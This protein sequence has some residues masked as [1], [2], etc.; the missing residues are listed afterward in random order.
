MAWTSAGADQR[1][2]FLGA[3]SALKQGDRQAFELLAV[4]LQEY[5]LYPYLRFEVLRRDLDSASAEEVGQFID[6]YGD[7]PLAERLRRI[8]LDRLAALSDWDG[9]VR[10]YRRGDSTER[11]C[12]YLQALTA[13]GRADEALPQVEAVWLS[14]K[15]RPRACD[16][17]IETWMDA[18][19]LT[20]DLVW[21]RIGLAM[22]AGQT[23]LARYLDR[24]L[25]PGE[26]TWL[27]R[28]LAL[29]GDPGRVLELGELPE[30]HPQRGRILAYGVERLARTS[31]ERAAKSLDLLER[32]GELSEDQIRS[33]AAAVGFALAERGDSKGLAYLDRV[34]A[35]NSNL[36]FQERRLRLA[37]TL[38]DWPVVARWVE[39]MP[40]GPQKTE[41]WV[42]WL[43][44]AREAE[45][46]REE[47]LRLFRQ[48]A[49]ERSLWGF[50]AAD[51]SGLP[52]RLDS[53][54]VP[55][56]PKRIASIAQGPAGQRIR[57]LQA[58]ERDLDV[59]REWYHLTR[60]LDAED[61][62]AAAVLACR[63]GLPDQ[64]IFTLARSDYWD[65]LAL[66]FPLLY[67][68]EVTQQ[69][70]ATGLDESLIYAVL[71]QESA[72]NPAAVSHAGAMGLMQLMPA[73]ARG[74][75]G[76]LGFSRPLWSDLLDPTP[77]ITLGSTY[78]AEMQDRFGGHPALAA[79]AYNA[80]PERVERWI[81]ETPMDADLW[82]ATIPFTETRGYVRRVLAYRVI[83]DHRLGR[84]IEP[85]SELMRPIGPGGG[86]PGNLG[87]GRPAEGWDPTVP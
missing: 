5:P 29:H 43:A 78:L 18:G 30:P 74:V 40:A 24:F 86:R 28:W 64:A 26:R 1:S 55:A 15:S 21:G 44:R 34:S 49:A 50:L 47:A 38:G 23:G 39:A 65:D 32:R 52:Y 17:V 2:A 14:G 87:E 71:R 56:D 80:G 79:A 35:E 54:P 41:H 22:D 46:K 75:A 83:Y 69:A 27:E 48:A 57:E 59:R 16:P 33:S 72:F 3:E 85:L 51:R 76:S 42:Y 66:R 13:T 63:W 58:L 81:P 67:R 53:R 10:L 82:V 8:W 68:D 20:T 36:A 37:L 77:N 61:L 12:R 6:D 73:T 60:D 25:P 4:G 19:R 45:G 7:T 84:T 9:Y 62:K 11:R 70:I 31:P